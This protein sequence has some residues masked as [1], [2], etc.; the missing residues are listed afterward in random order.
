LRRL[1]GDLR[2]LYAQL[3]ELENFARFGAEL[4]PATRQRLERGRRLREA[5]K[6]PRLRPLRPGQEAA[7]LFAVRQAYLN[8]LALDKVAA[9]LE[10]L[11]ERLERLDCDLLGV[12]ERG[13]ELNA[14]T[15]QHL[16]QVLTTVQ[17]PFATEAS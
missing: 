8:V 4:E 13:A 12:L 14:A 16:R 9:F 2:L 15:E 1:A 17:R 3:H 11:G 7:L 6:Q 5:L 10:A